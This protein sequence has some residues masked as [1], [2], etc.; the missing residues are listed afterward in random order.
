MVKAEDFTLFWYIN[1]AL[2]TLS[3]FPPFAK[4]ARICYN[5][6][7]LNPGGL[8]LRYRLAKSGL[9]P[10]KSHFVSIYSYL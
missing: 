9:K 2:N 4:E 5:R 1:C 6:L 3:R 7:Y 8:A 10:H